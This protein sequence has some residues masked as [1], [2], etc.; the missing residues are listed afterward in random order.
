MIAAWVTFD[1]PLGPG[2]GV[3]YELPE[4]SAALQAPA[5]GGISGPVAPPEAAAVAGPGVA[6]R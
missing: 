2:V 6:S 5:D 4:P 3:Y 1:L